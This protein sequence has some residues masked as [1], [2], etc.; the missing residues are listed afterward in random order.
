ML[1]LEEP[2][3]RKDPTLWEVMKSLWGEIGK[4]F[5]DKVVSDKRTL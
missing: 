4:I 2:T 1:G 3:G 5:W